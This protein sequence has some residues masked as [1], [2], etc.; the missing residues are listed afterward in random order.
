MLKI[1][2]TRSYIECAKAFVMN[3][4]DRLSVKKI[5]HIVDVT[6]NMSVRTGGPIFT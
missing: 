1:R 6:E 5:R 4:Q 2:Q 3:D